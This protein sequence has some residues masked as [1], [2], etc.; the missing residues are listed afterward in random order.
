MK[1]CTF[2]SGSSGNCTFVESGGERILIDAGI[3]MRR[4]KQSLL[5]HGIT[6]DGLGGILITHEHSDHVAGLK[7]LLKY[8]PGI[9]L[10]CTAGTAASLTAQ[11]PEAEDSLT[12]FSAGDGFSV[13]NLGVTSFKT[14][15]DT[16]ESVG[17]SITDGVKTL[18]FATDLCYVSKTVF[19]AVRGAD[20]AVLEANHDLDMLKNGSYPLFVGAD[21]LERWAGDEG[22]AAVALVFCDK[23]G[24]AHVFYIGGRFAR[25]EP[26]RNLNSCGFTHAVYQNVGL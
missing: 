8:Y 12:V 2:A 7:M 10:Y 6:P 25:A 20:F 15:H 21:L 17:Y 13:G 5:P 4:I 22:E 24:T 19:D 9:K 23:G 3:S 11:L 26:F 14:P 16:P 1:I 18:A